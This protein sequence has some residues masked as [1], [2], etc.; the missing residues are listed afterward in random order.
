MPERILDLSSGTNLPASDDG[1]GGGTEEA[2]WAGSQ[3][4]TWERAPRTEGERRRGP[5][6]PLHKKVEVGSEHRRGVGVEE[7]DSA[8]QRLDRARDAAGEHVEEEACGGGRSRCAGEL[9][10]RPVAAAPMFLTSCS[11]FGFQLGKPPEPVGLSAE[12]SMTATE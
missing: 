9:V 4:K 2:G 6:A 12:I 8:Q 11:S 5:D 1:G 7:L 3:R 10:Q